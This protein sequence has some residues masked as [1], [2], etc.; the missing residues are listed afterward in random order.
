MTDRFCPRVTAALRAGGWHPGRDVCAQLE[1]VLA[2]LAAVTG[3]AGQRHQVFP[4]A[5][6][7]LREFDSVVVAQ[8]GPGAAVARRPFAIDPLL[9][10]HT[11]ATLAAAGQALGVRLFPVGCE[12]LDAAVLAVD[13]TGRLLALDHAGEWLL[14][15]TFDQG[16]T[17]L[18]TGAEPVPL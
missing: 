7:V 3:A 13:E 10:A 17:A 9:V 11:T 15:E 14:G 1:P 5:L 6:A 12:G 8:D 2:E 4:A 16:V 18:V